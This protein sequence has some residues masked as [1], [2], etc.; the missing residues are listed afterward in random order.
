M[1]SRVDI[2]WLIIQCGPCISLSHTFVGFWLVIYVWQSKQFPFPEEGTVPAMC[3]E[4]T[5]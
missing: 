2:G 4:Y 1:D 5:A 3:V